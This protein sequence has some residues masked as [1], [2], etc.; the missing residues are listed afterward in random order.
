[1]IDVVKLVINLGYRYFDCV[2]LYYN[3]SEVGMGIS[4]KIKEGVV[5]REDFFVVSKVRFFYF[6][7]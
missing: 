5:K 6:R 1:M 2:Y 7:R 4:E 3:E